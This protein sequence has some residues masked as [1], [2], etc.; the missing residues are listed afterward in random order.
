MCGGVFPRLLQDHSSI[1]EPQ[2]MVV[3]GKQAGSGEALVKGSDARRDSST[4]TIANKK[5][6]SSRVSLA[7]NYSSIHISG[8]QGIHF[9]RDVFHLLNKFARVCKCFEVVRAL[10]VS[11]FLVPV[12]FCACTA[13]R[14]QLIECE[15]VVGHDFQLVVEVIPP[16]RTPSP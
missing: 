2:C 14:L 5:P 16:T 13:K 3:V 1:G 6:R 15:F 4:D 7:Q 9:T 8:N 10:C 12:G 11:Q